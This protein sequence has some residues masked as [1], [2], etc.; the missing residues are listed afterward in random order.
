M[1]IAFSCPGCGKQFKVSDTMAGRK[2]KCSACATVMLVPSAEQG[3]AAAPTRQPPPPPADDYGG[4]EPAPRKVKKRK[5][6]RT[7][8]LI[9]LLGL[10]GAVLG[11]CVCTGGF[12]GLG[13]FNVWDPLA[14]FG[15]LPAEVRYLPDRCSVVAVVNV[16]QMQDSECY[17]QMKKE[18][19]DIKD[20]DI[21]DKGLGIAG[22]NVQ[23]MVLGVVLPQGA[24]FMNMG[25][26]V[27][28]VRVVKTKKAVT[29]SDIVSKRGNAQFK[30]I[31]VKDYTIYELSGQSF[32]VVEDTVVI[33]S[34]KADTL[35]RVLERDK[36]PEFSDDMQ[37][38][39]KQ[40][41]FSKSVGFA[42]DFKSFKG[43]PSPPMPGGPRPG[44]PGGDPL[45]GIK[46][47]TD[48]AEGLGGYVHM[49]SDLDLNVTVLC[50]DSKGA[51][52]I[53]K[54][55]DGILTLGKGFVPPE[56]KELIEAIK[57]TTSGSKVI[58]SASYKTETLVKVGKAGKA[59]KFMKF[60]QAAPPEKNAVARAEDPRAAVP[61]AGH[62]AGPAL[63]VSGRRF[64]GR[65]RIAE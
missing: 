42:V 49:G 1:T 53:K 27:E 60:G 34:A 7:G 12:L 22:T 11:C 61:L 14:L 35:K 9:A 39:I 30:Q 3:V 28:E 55:M 63:T 8:L 45:Q 18:F 31:K 24:G 40:A 32:C 50:Q 29:A 56:M 64:R 47:V 46:D 15:S 26:N 62:A 36:K 37:A 51:D 33:F 57:I 59:G 41:N 5:K 43:P 17:K 16:E 20:D 10:G 25:G 19:P 44:M 23:R 4:D 58:A 2:A 65:D 6:S 48:K 21:V 52:D 13:Y 54:S 38:A